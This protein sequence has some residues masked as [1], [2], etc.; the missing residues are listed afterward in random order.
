[1]RARV[2]MIFLPSIF[3]G[4]GNFSQERWNQRINYFAASVVPVKP[5]QD[6]G[7]A[8]TSSG[9]EENSV[10]MEQSDNSYSETTG[11]TMDA[12]EVDMSS[13]SKGY[14]SQERESADALLQLHTTVAK[15]QVEDAKTSKLNR[16]LKE[17]IALTKK[18][19]RPRS[20]M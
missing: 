13:G 17:N 10:E 3:F 2:E 16:L 8:D 15:E 14:T 19:P 5:E 6:P 9:C 1:M 20:Q 12:D 7:A 18:N 11:G 4:F